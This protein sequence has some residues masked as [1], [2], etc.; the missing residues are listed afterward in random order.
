MTDQKVPAVVV[1]GVD[2]SP[3]SVEALRWALEQ[4]R[5]TG[6]EIRALMAWDLPTT[7]GYAPTYDDID[8][9]EAA[10]ETLDQAVADVRQ[11][12]S[13]KLSTELIRGHAANVLIKASHDADLLVVGS[14]GHGTVTEMLVGSVSRH[15][16]HHAAC[17]VVVVPPRGH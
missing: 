3:G 2:G 10:Q 6:A 9:A 12:P 1:V 11:D 8:W 5:V 14:R 13:V 16:V 17:P 7:Y 4:A 15:C